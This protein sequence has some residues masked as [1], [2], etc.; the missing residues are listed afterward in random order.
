MEFRLVYRGP[1]KANGSVDDKQ[2]LRRAFH[3]QL[4]ELWNQLPLKEITEFLKAKPAARK[5]SLIHPIDTFQFAPLVSARINLIC[6]LNILFLRPGEPGSLI[7][8]GGDIDNR[9]K[10]LLD[11]LRMPKDSRELPSGDHPLPDEDPFFC[12]LEDDALVTNVS[13]TTDPLLEQAQPTEVVL[14]VQVSVRATRVSND[15]IGLIG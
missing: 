5:I 10:T 7:Q 12:L 9:L 8:H 15:N 11:G 1:L 13:V 4:R 2:K 14:V 3:G 6:G